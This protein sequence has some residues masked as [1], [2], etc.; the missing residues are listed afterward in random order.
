MGCSPWGGGLGGQGA[1]GGLSCQLDN[2]LEVWSVPFHIQVHL[3]T[4]LFSQEKLPSE[5]RGMMSVRQ[6]ITWKERSS[7]QKPLRDLNP[8]ELKGPELD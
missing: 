4:L 5:V 8:A 1:G 2:S 6:A 7:A 3:K